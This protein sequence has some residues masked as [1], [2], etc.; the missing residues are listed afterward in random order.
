MIKEERDYHDLE[1][2]ARQVERNLERMTVSRRAPGSQRGSWAGPAWLDTVKCL[3]CRSLQ[4]TESCPGGTWVWVGPGRPAVSRGPSPWAAQPRGGPAWPGPPGEGE[5]RG[6]RG[7]V[8]CPRYHS[9]DAFF[10]FFFCGGNNR[11]GQ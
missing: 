3:V 4:G 7:C 11:N 9:S 10:F 1:S 5:G 2:V 8:L 6:G